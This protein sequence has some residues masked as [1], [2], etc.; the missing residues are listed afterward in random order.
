MYQ[1]S[2][3]D[4]LVKILTIGETGVGKTCLIS[5]YT[6]NEFFE[7][8]LATIAIDFKMKNMDID[9]KKVKIQI[10]DTA[11][12]ER[13]AIMTNGFFKNADGILLT[14]SINDE[15]SF[16]AV[17]KWMLQIRDKA[18]SDVNIILVGNKNDMESDR[19]VS[20]DEGRKLAEHYGITFLEASAKNGKNVKEVFEKLASE[21]ID[22]ND[23]RQLGQVKVNGKE[24]DPE[25]TIKEQKGCC[26]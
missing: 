24:K 23:K 12:Q 2:S 1:D 6:R 15:R 10:W 25:L 17:T 18:P 3:F 9:K 16:E 5:R 8:H 14:Y 26:K 19:K 21:I 20:Y 11:G 22:K 7:T 4:H 13:F